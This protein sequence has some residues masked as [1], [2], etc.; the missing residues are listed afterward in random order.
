MS[1]EVRGNPTLTAVPIR[2]NTVGDTTAIQRASIPTLTGKKAVRLTFMANQVFQWFSPFFYFLLAHPRDITE[3]EKNNFE[4]SD[5]KL[6][7]EIKDPEK[8]ADI[9]FSILRMW[10]IVE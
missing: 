10:S 8:N 5:T 3:R 4:C 1:L 9:L 7:P 6:G 2:S